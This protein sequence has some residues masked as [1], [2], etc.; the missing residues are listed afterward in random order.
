M[1]SAAEITGGRYLFLTDDSGVGGPHKTPEIPCYFVTKLA[2]AL[3]RAGRDGSLGQLHRAR[4]GR[5]RS[6]GRRSLERRQV[7]D[8]GRA[9]GPDLLTDAPVE[10]AARRGRCLAA[11]ARTDATWFRC[12]LSRPPRYSP[13]RWPRRR[14]VGARGDGGHTPEDVARRAPPAIEV[15]VG[16]FA[17]MDFGSICR[18]ESDV[19]GC[20]NGAAFAG[21]SL[22]PRWRLSSLFSLVA[23]GCRR[24]GTRRSGR[25]CLV[26]RESQ[27]FPADA[28]AVW[29]PRRA[30]ILSVPISSILGSDSRRA[31]L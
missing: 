12:A 14:C 25:R 4:S 30:G 10:D 29:R 21:I 23:M 26:G 7:H 15:G 8:G 19:I 13:S 6:H 16:G 11:L 31:S 5:R 28:V 20:T 3:V 1:R 17:Q 24:L 18:R 9:D 27:G 22:A 2:R